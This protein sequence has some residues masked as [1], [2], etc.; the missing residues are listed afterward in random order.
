MEA[1]IG[2]AQKMISMRCKKGGS[3]SI[4]PIRK[5]EC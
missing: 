5:F 2:E 3:V 1:Q 4:R